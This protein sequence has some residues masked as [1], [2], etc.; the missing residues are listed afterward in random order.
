VRYLGRRYLISYAQR[1]TEDLG[2]IK[3]GFYVNL[4]KARNPGL[5]NPG[6]QTQVF[7]I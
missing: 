7:K 6:E 4:I 2:L 5:H 1:C 3:A